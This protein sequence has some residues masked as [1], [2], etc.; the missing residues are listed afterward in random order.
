MEKAEKAFGENV[1]IYSPMKERQIRVPNSEQKSLLLRPVDN[2]IELSTF[3]K[4]AWRYTTAVADRLYA[5]VVEIMALSE[6][7][8]W[9]KIV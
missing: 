2:W 1:K 7:K 5:Q 4:C 3:E 8:M 6:F 9:P